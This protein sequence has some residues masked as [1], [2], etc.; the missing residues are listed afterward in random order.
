MA[1]LLNVNKHGGIWEFEGVGWAIHSMSNSQCFA[2]FEC[3]EFTECAN[4][5]YVT[6]E[7]VLRIFTY[8]VLPCKDASFALA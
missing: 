5:R 6:F 8:A 2:L 7:V 3:S 4:N 1:A